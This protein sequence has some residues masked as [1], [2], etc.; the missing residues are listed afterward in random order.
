MGELDQR[1]Y[2][3]DEGIRFACQQCGACCTGAPG[4]VRV[5]D[6]EIASIAAFLGLSVEA[7]V[8][9]TL[10]VWEAGHSVREDRDGRCLF[11]E[12][13]CRIYPVRPNQCRTFPFWVSLLRSEARW[14]SIR[15]HCPGIGKGRRY[16]GAEIVDVLADSIEPRRSFDVTRN[17]SSSRPDGI[18]P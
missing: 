4:V 11:Y 17:P 13:G 2:F 18:E 1:P 7:T 8:D 3:F 14:H 15:R 12:D 16:S 6:S 9:R 10:V 5:S